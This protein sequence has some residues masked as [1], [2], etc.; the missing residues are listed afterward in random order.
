MITK[1]ISG[2][3]RKFRYS[4]GSTIII[5]AFILVLVGVFC[6]IE[7][8]CAFAIKK[9]I[10]VEDYIQELKFRSWKLENRLHEN[11]DDMDAKEELI[12]LRD[13]YLQLLKFSIRELEERLHQ[14]P[15]D[16]DAK[17]KI[18]KL[19]NEYLQQL[20]DSIHR[21]EIKLRENPDDTTIQEELNRLREELDWS[22]TIKIKY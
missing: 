17:E 22:H 11:P 16:M 10:I 20:D 18:I 12:K 14:N 8:R 5:T 13:E 7:T 6:L 2:I 19:N 3:M 15:D 9:Q 1:A 4:I 21:L